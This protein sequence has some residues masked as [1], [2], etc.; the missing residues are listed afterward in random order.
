MDK[1]P[2]R[3]DDPTYFFPCSCDKCSRAAAGAWMG[4]M[5][6]VIGGDLSLDE[7]NRLADSDP[8][9]TPRSR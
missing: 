4:Y 5:D 1:R 3:K 6:R 8:T 7:A 2:C 9:I